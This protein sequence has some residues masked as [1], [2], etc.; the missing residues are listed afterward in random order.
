MKIKLII[1]F[2]LFIAPAFFAQQAELSG[3]QG[4]FCNIGLGA[5]PAALGNAYAATANDVNSVLWNPAG[6][7][8]INKMQASFTFT[9]LLGL[10]DYNSISFAMPFGTDQGLGA[11][12]ISSGDKQMHEYTFNMAYSRWLMPSKLSVGVALK[13]RYASFGNNSLNASDY[14]LFE[15]DE[16]QE[17]LLNQVKGSAIGF[18]MDIGLLYNLHSNVNVGIMLKDIYS[19]LFWDSKVDNPQ[20]HAKGSYNEIVPFEPTAGMSML[21]FDQALRVSADYSSAM[22]RETSDNFRSGMELKLINM[23]YLRGGMQHYVSNE[24]NNKYSFGLGIDIGILDDMRVQVDYAYLIENLANTQHFTLSM[25][26]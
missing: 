8:Q 9:K 19:P 2:V 21:L 18:G 25:E 16:I 12:L 17:G 7:S 5:R 6:M 10:V 26:F 15:P 3:I 22:S 20:K 24:A 14:S 13:M 4:A 11:A 1:A 23:I